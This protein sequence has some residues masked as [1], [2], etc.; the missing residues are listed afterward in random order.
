MTDQEY[1]H[2]IQRLKESPAKPTVDVVLPLVRHYC[3]QAEGLGGCLH[4][5]VEDGNVEADHIIACK[6]WAIEQGDQMCIALCDVLID[7]SKTQLT[8]I[9][10]RGYEPPF[11]DEI[12]QDGGFELDLTKDSA[13]LVVSGEQVRCLVVVDVTPMTKEQRET[14]CQRALVA[15]YRMGDKLVQRRNQN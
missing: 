12:K 8:E 11:K 1:Y 9:Y 13:Q 6:D 4:I 5:F 2:D 15:M 10:N 3:A 14:F 7:M